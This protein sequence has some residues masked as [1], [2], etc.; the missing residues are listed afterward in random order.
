MP[1][2]PNE[3]RYLLLPTLHPAFVLRSISDRR[4]R[5]ALRQ[6]ASDI[7]KAVRIYERYMLEVMGVTLSSRSDTT[8][9]QIEESVTVMR[10]QEED[11][12]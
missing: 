10:E 2:E 7:R 6:F 5:S 4:D 9:D 11:Y 8:D 3:V 1:T 12:G